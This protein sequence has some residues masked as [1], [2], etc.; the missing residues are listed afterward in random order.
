MQVDGVLVAVLR[1]LG[2]GPQRDL[3]QFLRDL[4]VVGAWGQDLNVAHLLQGGEVALTKEEALAGDHLVQA[5]SHGE[6]VGAAVQ[7]QAPH[8]LGRHIAELALED[9]SLGLGRLAHR[10]GDAEVHQLHL[11]LERD[12]DVLGADVAV[13]QVHLPAGVVPL[14]MGVVQP[15]ADLHDDEGGLGDGHDLAH[16]STAV[17]DGPQV[18]AVDVFQGDEVGAV[19]FAQ[20]EDLGDVGVVQL[21]RDLG[22]IDEH[23]DELFIF[24]DVGQDLLDRDEALKP[25]HAV[26][27]TTEDLGHTSNGDPLKEVVFSERYRPLHFRPSA[28]QWVEKKGAKSVSDSISVII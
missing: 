9:A 21:D 25:L 15:L 16:G 23:G 5:D 24:C 10:L 11:S 13:D 4:P 19:H 1:I 12:E 22:L 14:V 8:L 3:L 20:V 28:W 26:G 2:Q 7:G 17:E 27:L 6:D 18:L